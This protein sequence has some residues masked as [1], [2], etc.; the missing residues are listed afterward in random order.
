MPTRISSAYAKIERSK[1]HIENLKTE[2]RIFLNRKPYRTRGYDEV[3]TGDRVIKLNVVEEC[4]VQIR[5]ILG[6]A[7]HNLRSSLDHIGREL[8][9]ISGGTPNANTGFPIV[10]EIANIDTE[11]SRKIPGARPEVITAVK[12]LQPYEGGKA[13]ILWRLHRLDI[14]DKHRLLIAVA[15]CNHWIDVRGVS[16]IGAYFPELARPIK[17]LPPVGYTLKQG[18]ELYRLRSAHREPRQPGVYMDPEFKFQVAFGE[19]LEGNP[20][21]PALEKCVNAVEGVITALSPLL[22]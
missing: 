6:D 4:P 10:N 16:A 18:T 8:C 5:L 14:I 22:V 1:E 17:G 15:S 13:D 11:I 7:I 3:N 20:I 19:I 21:V 2:L 12:A 9:L